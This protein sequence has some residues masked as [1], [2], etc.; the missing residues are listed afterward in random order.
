MA[1]DSVGPAMEA[2]SDRSDYPLYVVTVATAE[3]E[4]SGCLAGFVTQCSITPPRFL[5]CLSKL[6]HSF[7]VGEQATGI[8]L[9]LLGDD[10]TELA[11]LFAERTGDDYDKFEHCEWHRGVSAAPVLEH[12]AAWLEG[13]ILDRFSVGDHEALLMSPV[14][15]GAGHH[16]G[17]L[18]L[19]NAPPFRPGHPG[20][21]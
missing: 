2:F 15:G 11:S 14:T 5:V 6:N 16:T 17:L 19:S 10:Q 18:T 20:A 12:C 21:P 3:G 13:S 7:F 8:A 4:N 9:H 1:V